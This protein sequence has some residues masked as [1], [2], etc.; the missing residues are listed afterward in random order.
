MFSL[1]WRV[2]ATPSIAAKSTFKLSRLSDLANVAQRLAV[3]AQFGSYLAEDDI[4][5]QQIDRTVMGFCARAERNP[6]RT[7]TGL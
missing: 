1:L 4:A 3:R 5:Q 7:V 6:P 2:E